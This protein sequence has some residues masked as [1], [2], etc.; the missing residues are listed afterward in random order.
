MPKTTTIV[1]LLALV[2]TL[3]C[4]TNQTEDRRGEL[5]DVSETPLSLPLSLTASWFN[6]LGLSEATLPQ[7][8]I[9]V[10]SLTYRTINHQGNSVL[11]SG[12]VYVPV[13]TDGHSFP[14]ISIHH[15]TTFER[16]KVASVSAYHNSES[17]WA[18]A[19]GFVV[20]C[21]DGLGLGVS[22]EIHPY[23]LAE[24]SATAAI[25][26]LRA[27]KTFARNNDIPLN[28][29]LFLAGYS[30]GG[31]V[32][33][34]THKTIEEYYSDEFTVTASAPMAGPYDIR[35]MADL[36]I[37]SDTYDNPGYF[38]Y[39]FVA[40]KDVYDLPPISAI[41][42][43]PYAGYI[44]FLYDGT[45][46]GGEIN[47]SLTTVLADLFTPEFLAGFRGDG[48]TDLKTAME[49]NDVAH[50]APSA[51]VRLFHGM[52]DVTVPY[53]VS[54]A[55]AENMSLPLVSFPGDHGG[56]AIACIDSAY[57]WL[58]SFVTP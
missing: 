34:A 2:F 32:T 29:Q 43:E 22:D 36:V 39:I 31:Y 5:V 21:P 37:G 53:A 26:M 16:D 47:D 30:E 27:V 11:A 28:D 17:I 1:I 18:A 9:M 15:G 4:D 6:N 8:D 56:A 12:A 20:S 40:Y 48:Y 58:E 54:V 24:G 23:I 57:A 3:S 52:D 25:D 13:S 33:M 44:D 42:Q 49:D 46:S 38:G 45:H 19:N 35:F 55:A 10:Y 14:L 41:F 50:W 51:P 7:Y